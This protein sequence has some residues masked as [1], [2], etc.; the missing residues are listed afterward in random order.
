MVRKF[1]I[2]AAL[3]AVMHSRPRLSLSKPAERPTKPRPC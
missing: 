1:V 2:A 3:A